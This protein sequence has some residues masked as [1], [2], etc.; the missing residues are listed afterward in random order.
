MDKFVETYNLPKLNEEEAQRLNRL[1]TP[2]EIKA[3]IKIHSKQKPWTGLFPILLSW[4]KKLQEEG[5]LLNTFY[6]ASIIL[7]PKAD[8]DTL[9]ENYRTIT[10]I[11]IDTKIL[12]KVLVNFIQQYAKMIIHHDQVG[13]IPRVQGLY[14]ICKSVKIIPHISKR[15]HK[16]HMIM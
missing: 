5:R 4:F 14:N 15:K 10:L 3:V 8:N 12:N 7:I 16:N 11:N 1:I 6:E 9:K 2:A 13:V